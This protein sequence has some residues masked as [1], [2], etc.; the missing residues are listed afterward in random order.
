MVM[1]V[2]TL[3]PAMLITMTAFTR[4]L[5]VL[6]ILRQA[7]GTAQTPSNQIILGFPLFD[8]IYHVARDRFSVGSV[9]APYLDG[10]VG[11]EE[12]LGTAQVPLREFMFSQTRESIWP[13]SL[14][15]RCSAFASR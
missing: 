2:L 5:I 11:F 15:W 7:L 14:S 8:P 13:C 1:M 10:Q 12:A 6:A 9:L 4:I 3:L